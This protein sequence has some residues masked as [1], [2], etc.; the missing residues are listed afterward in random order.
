[1]TRFPTPIMV[2]AYVFRPLADVCLG[3]LP[4]DDLDVWAEGIP[5][6]ATDDRGKDQEAGGGGRLL[7]HGQDQLQKHFRADERP[8]QLCRPRALRETQSVRSSETATLQ[9]LALGL[10][11]PDTAL[12]SG[13]RTE[14]SGG[15]ILVGFLPHAPHLIP[16][17]KHFLGAGTILG[18]LNSGLYAR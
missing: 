1:M 2:P 12:C 6:A 15:H 9:V 18:G 5:W 13:R 10:W 14:A 8:N 11:P 16:V 4:G 3:Q 17:P 7:Q